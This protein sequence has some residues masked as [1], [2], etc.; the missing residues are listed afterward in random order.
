MMERFE[1]QKNLS[2]EERQK[3]VGFSE[4]LKSA[5]EPE[6]SQEAD[7]L[8][9]NIEYLKKS[10]GSNPEHFFLWNFIMSKGLSTEFDYTNF[11]TPDGKI[12]S[13]IK[14][15]SEKEFELAA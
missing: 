1:Q 2:E 8:A 6:T 9:D 5:F 7:Q 3:L 15:L 11:D 10:L 12:E 4:I 14:D 13:F